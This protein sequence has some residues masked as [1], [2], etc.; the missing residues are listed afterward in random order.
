MRF[1]DFVNA[2]QRSITDFEHQLAAGESEII[3]LSRDAYLNAVDRA[4]QALKKQSNVEFLQQ[5]ATQPF[6]RN[7]VPGEWTDKVVGDIVRTH[8]S[9]LSE[10]EW[11]NT[12]RPFYNV[13]PIVEQL[14]RNTK[15]DVS[16]AFLNFPQRTMLFRFAEGHEPYGI[17]SVLITVG[18]P[19]VV[20]ENTQYFTNKNVDVFAGVIGSAL[21]EYTKPL[22][23]EHHH[24]EVYLLGGVY[25]DIPESNDRPYEPSFA[26]GNDHESIVAFQL[27][28]TRYQAMQAPDDLQLAV[29]DSY[30]F[31]RGPNMFPVS[32]N[33]VVR[34]K[35]IEETIK[36]QH[37]ADDCRGQRL[38]LYMGYQSLEVNQFVFKLASFASMLHCGS[39][40]ITPIVLAKHQ[41][42]YDRETD[43]AA[44]KWLEDKAAN[45]Q[46]R[47][48]SIGKKLN[49]QSL[50]SPHWRN[51]HMALYWTGVG[52]KEPKLILRAGAVVVPKH[53]SR[54]PTGFLGEETLNESAPVKT[55]EHVYFLQEPT[56]GY[57]KIG[58]TRRAVEARQRES[59]TFVPGG[60]KLVGYIV[61]G[62]CVALETRL[63][64]EYADKRQDNEFFDIS[65]DDAHAIITQFGGVV[66]GDV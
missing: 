59:Q 35:T 30:Q 5:M 19:H 12:E 41:E 1:H 57:I 44:K 49:A 27:E 17:K 2:K 52:R 53:L 13:Y 23:G 15:L 34:L 47:G 36:H 64:R 9:V 29:G 62:D 32:Q 14:I 42:R 51:P 50:V 7:V 22:P 3:G 66:G 55:D 45:I 37:A 24:H 25:E 65:V 54:V 18:Q 26:A 39:D 4:L 31:T 56:R 58:R 43:E 6:D 20:P 11:Y 60:L 61:T 10:Y 38:P 21:V 63:H 46:G 16:A 33:S 40:L 28:A 8:I 48:F